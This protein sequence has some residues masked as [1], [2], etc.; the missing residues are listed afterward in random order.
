[1]ESSKDVFNKFFKELPREA[2]DVLKERTVF[3]AVRKLCYERIFH[4]EN[5]IFEE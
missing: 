3:G 4:F 2:V 1:M 5:T